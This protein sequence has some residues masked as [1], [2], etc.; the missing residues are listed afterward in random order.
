MVGPRQDANVLG[1]RHPCCWSLPQRWPMCLVFIYNDYFVWGSRSGDVWF[2]PRQGDPVGRNLEVETHVTTS[3]PESWSGCITSIFFGSPC[4]AAAYHVH[5]ISVCYLFHGG[6][7]S[8]L[9]VSLGWHFFTWYMCVRCRRCWSL[10][11]PVALDLMVIIV[12]VCHVKL[13][14]LLFLSV[15]G[16]QILFWGPLSLS[17]LFWLMF[18]GDLAFLRWGGVGH[19]PCDGSSRRRTPLAHKSLRL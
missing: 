11:Q 13:C 17:V 16:C 10:F 2:V 12:N 15:A 5:V 18:T 6:R 19:C 9:L 1:G 4:P 8:L 3:A 14:V 7:V